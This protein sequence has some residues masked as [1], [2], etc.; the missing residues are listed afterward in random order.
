MSTITGDSGAMPASIRSD[1]QRRS[2]KQVNHQQCSHN[3]YKSPG[4]TSLSQAIH[5]LHPDTTGK[6]WELT[7]WDSNKSTVVSFAVNLPTGHYQSLVGW[8]DDSPGQD[9]ARRIHIQFALIQNDIIISIGT[10]SRRGPS[11]Y[12]Y[13]CISTPPTHKFKWTGKWKCS[14]NC[15]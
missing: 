4:N 10:T 13:Y 6:R 5:F 14:G 1:Q 12:Y 15:I 11:N 8:Q 2:R 3:S 9:S 7:E